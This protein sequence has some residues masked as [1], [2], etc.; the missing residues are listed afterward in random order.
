[1][2]NSITYEEARDLLLKTV[3]PVGTEQVG[4]ADCI[5]M[6]LAEDVVASENVPPFDRSPYDGYALRAKDTE[7]AA[8]EQPIEL[9]IIEEVPAGVVAGQRVEAGT[10]V[11]ILTGAP[12]PDGADAVIMY[13]ETEYTDTTVRIFQPITSG[14]NIIRAGEDVRAGQLL[15]QKGTRID[16]GLLG[17]L[18]AQGIAAPKVYRPPH[19]GFISTGNEIIEVGKPLSAGKIYN[20]NRYSIEAVLNQ[21]GCTTEY[22]GIAE[23]QT[24]DIAG[25]ITQALEHCD[26]VLLTGGVSAGEYDLT[27]AA[28]ELAGVTILARRVKIKPGMACAYGEKDGKLVCGLSGNPVAAIA[29]LHLVVL[30]AL[31]RLCGMAE[32]LPREITVTLSEPFGKKS[33]KVRPLYGTLDLEQGTVR[34]H[35]PQEQGNAIVSSLIGCDVIALVPEGSGALEAETKLKGFMI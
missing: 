31:K 21:I 32:V 22:L 20:T 29:N 7:N 8:A 28:M 16:V 33:K 18:A 14:S 2:K 24:E 19:I 25:R 5:G 17:T 12:I 1:M 10:A 34:M 4:I 11:K 6:V 9:K 3:Q 23:D 15:A 30:P 27:P 13:E 26:A 35:V